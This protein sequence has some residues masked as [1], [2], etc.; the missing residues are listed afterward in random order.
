MRLFQPMYMT[1]R[2]CAMA[3]G[4]PWESGASSQARNASALTRSAGTR[5]ETIQ[6]RARP[7][8]CSLWPPSEQARSMPMSSM[9]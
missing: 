6:S 5:I 3:A 1:P 8:L 9:P 2:R 7:S 4:L